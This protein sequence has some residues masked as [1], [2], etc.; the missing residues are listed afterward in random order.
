[1]ARLEGLTGACRSS[2][3]GIV[4]PETAKPLSGTAEMKRLLLGGPGSPPFGLRPG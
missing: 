4:I 2:K 1:M 3:S